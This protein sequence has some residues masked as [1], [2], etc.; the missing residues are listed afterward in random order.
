MA[1]IAFAATTSS[2]KIHHRMAPEIRRC[3]PKG[4]PNETPKT[5]LQTK[6]RNPQFPSQRTKQTLESENLGITER[7]GA[8]M[9]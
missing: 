1:I 9:G 2:T 4:P 5:I 7:T 6:T 3:T 8:M